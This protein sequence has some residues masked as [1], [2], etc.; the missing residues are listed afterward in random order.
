MGGEWSAKGVPNATRKGATYGPGLRQ[1]GL[2][3]GPTLVLAWAN[4]GPNFG[5]TLVQVWTNFGSSFEPILVQV[6]TNL[7][8][9]LGQLW[10]QF[11][12]KCGPRMEPSLD[13]PQSR[14][15]TIWAPRLSDLPWKSGGGL[16]AP[17]ACQVDCQ[18]TGNEFRRAARSQIGPRRAYALLRAREHF[19]GPAGSF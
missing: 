13:Q 5:P 7:G 14:C 9:G 11:W 17:S 6:W 2:R 15:W 12:T 8:P 1:L 4:F 10:V 18:L 19:T 3:L 16:P